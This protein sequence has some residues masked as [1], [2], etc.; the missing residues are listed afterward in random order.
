[1][2][3]FARIMSHGFALAIVALLAIGLIYRGELFPDMELPE[4]LQVE[5]LAKDSREAPADT[6]SDKEPA[7]ASG[8]P[9]A[10]DRDTLAAGESPDTSAE[11]AGSPSGAADTG[12]AAVTSPAALPADVTPPADMP[13]PQAE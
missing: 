11:T 6:G 7:Q 5:R 12:S 13:P 10:V 2:S 3:L 8:D 9:A 1:M 4:F